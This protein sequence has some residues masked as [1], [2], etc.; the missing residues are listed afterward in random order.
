MDNENEF[1]YSVD[2]KFKQT[3]PPKKSGFGRTVFVPFLAGIVGASLTVGVC[4]KVPEVRKAL[5]GEQPKTS[6][7]APKTESNKGTSDTATVSAD[8]MAFS[9]N[10]I[11]VAKT[12]LPSI[13]GIEIKYN[14]SSFW[15]NSEATATGSGVIISEDGYIITNNHVVSTE[16]SSSSFYT[17]TEAKGLTVKLYG[18]EKE[19]EAKIIGTDAYTDLAVI[20]IDATGLTPAVLGDSDELQ[21]GEFAMAIGN[22]LGMDFTVTSGIISAVN[23]EVSA[24]DGTSYLAIQTD[25]AI[26]S[27]NS[28]GA[29]VNLKGEVIGINNLKLSGEGIEGI[30]F[31]IPINST[32]DVVNQLIEFK[33]VKRPYIGVTGQGIDSSITEIYGLPA[34]VSVKEVEEGSPADKAGLQKGD[35]ITKIESKEVSTV[36]ELNKVKYTYKIGD[37]V[38]LTILRNGQ[39]QEIK[40]TLGEEPVQ[41]GEDETEEK[42]EASTKVDAKKD[43]SSSG[44]RGSSS[45]PSSIWDLFR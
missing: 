18:D 2:Q 14:V 21:V 41:E 22:P 11:Q 27:G 39:E 24:S 4:F 19:Y 34:G 32:T 16:T 5:I 38:T 7:S 42:E 1:N 17:I 31:A 30:G 12:V 9:N 43:N 45:F 13:V 10:S 6:Y 37:T 20:K 28:G 25:A 26:N 8:Y 29:L 15:G 23:R 40:L 33:T 44:S 3:K 36:T 35:I